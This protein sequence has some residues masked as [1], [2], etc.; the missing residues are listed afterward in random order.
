MSNPK[1]VRNCS[2]GLRAPVNTFKGNGDGSYRPPQ[3]TPHSSLSS[4]PTS[5][6]KTVAVVVPLSERACLTP[7]EQ[8]SFRHLI[9]YLGKYDKYLITPRSLRARHDGIAIKEFDDRYFGSARAHAR[10]LFSSSFYDAFSEYEYILIYHLDALVLS[11]QLL[12][13]CQK[14]FD[15]I[16]APWFPS[17]ATPWIKVPRVGNGGFS[18]RRVQSFLNIIRS[19]VYQVDPAAYWQDL[20]A[21]KSGYFRLCNLPRKY[22]KSL[23]RFNGA[24]WE[25][26]QWLR[27][28]DRH[29]TN[30][31]FFW[32]DRGS[33]YYPEF[34]VAPFEEGLRFAFEVDPRHCFELNNHQLPFGCHA[35]PRYDRSFWEPYLLP[36]TEPGESTGN[37]RL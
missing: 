21:G 36:S 29:R 25:M 18:L 4:P 27:H 3:A 31:E 22:L 23:R 10:L 2:G 37:M 16:G 11:D 34:K 13:W 35:W 8:V 28:Y 32:V 1:A 15:Y 7:E 12:Q 14:G 6:K 24:Q 20:C 5:R 33:H 30:E 26:R 19:S 9:H 17:E